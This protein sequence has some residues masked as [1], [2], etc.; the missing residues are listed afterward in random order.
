MK[1][2]RTDGL[3]DRQVLRVGQTDVRQEKL[4]VTAAPK[5]GLSGLMNVLPGLPALQ[6]C[7]Q[8]GQKEQ[9]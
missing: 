6:K 5:Y 9:L 7:L 3:S 4:G 8:G 1:V 2:G